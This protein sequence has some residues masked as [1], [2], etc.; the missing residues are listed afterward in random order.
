MYNRHFGLS[1]APFRIT[2]DTRHFFGGGQ[3]A[4]VLNS[5][6]YAITRGEGMVKV[7]GEV[8][9][10]KTMLCHML[11]DQLPDSVDVVYL[12]NPGLTRNEILAAIAL[13]LNLPAG[14]DTPHLQLQQQLQDY[15]LEAH[16]NKRQVV[17]FVE[18]AQQM[19]LETLEEIRL[20]S[21]LETRHSKLL[22][23]VLFG[24]PELNYLI[25]KHEIR[26]LRDRISHCFNL[27]PLSMAEIRDYI[28]FRLHSAGY[29]GN[30]LFTA[31]A[32]RLLAIFSRGLIRRLN[33][34]ADKAL[35]AAFAAQS[36]RVCWKH[37]W[38]ARYDGASPGR[39][40][41]L[42]GGL[43]AGLGAGTAV[44]LV[45][46][47]V[48]NHY[49]PPPPDTITPA[50]QISQNIDELRAIA[51]QTRPSSGGLPLVSQRLQASND[52]LQRPAGRQLTIQLLLTENDDLRTVEKLLEKPLYNSLLP[53]VYLYRSEVAGRQRWNILFGEFDSKTKA[54][55]A[56]A[57]LPERIQRH[58]PYL[59]SLDPLRTRFQTMGTDMHREEQ[60]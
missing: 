5:L 48:F 53:D 27:S 54:L 36:S 16:R 50:T 21:N 1:A 9:T 26:Q 25:E 35:L 28:R 52:W 51:L 7:T 30:D 42:P 15:L 59:R 29:R 60:G 3:R 43:A 45:G 19:S 34:L 57:D 39:P 49:T 14:V 37:V 17:V 10:G 24:Q 46:I 32:Y 56:L 38:R 31:T 41:L 2:P 47:A 22:Q 18:E 11:Q 8:G 4:E 20:L 23:L 58:Q 6:L 40:Q 44:A 33:I 12:T 55:A 13:E